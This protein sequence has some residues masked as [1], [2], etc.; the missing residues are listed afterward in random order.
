MAS[1]S[2][3]KAEPPDLPYSIEVDVERDLIRMKLWGFW[4]RAMVERFAAD[5]QRATRYLRCARGAHVVL[6]ES[7]GPPQSQEVIAAMQDLVV[8]IPNKAARFAL[9]TSGAISDLQGRRLLIRPG[10]AIFPD[11]PSSDD[12]LFG[13]S[14]TA[15]RSP[16]SWAE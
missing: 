12:W 13:S 9:V 10:M 7:A 15:A 16:G 3:E 5:Q 11:V 4:D 14:E 8:N 1:R 6:C 2:P